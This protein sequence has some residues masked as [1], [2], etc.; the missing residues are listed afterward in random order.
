MHRGKS[1]FKTFAF[2][3]NVL[4]DMLIQIYKEMRRWGITKH[5]KYKA[6]G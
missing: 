1:H 4:N 3:K 5:C 6:D 2:L